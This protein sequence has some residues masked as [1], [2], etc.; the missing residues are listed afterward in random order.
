M[1]TFYCTNCWA[2]VRESATICP[3][4][5]DDIATRQARADYVDKLIAALHHPIPETAVRAACILGE[6]RERKAVPALMQTV[7]ESENLF[8]VDAAVEA[9]GKIGDPQALETLHEAARHASARLRRTVGQALQQLNRET[10]S[11]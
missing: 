2:E 10:I 9:L 5:G 6:R 7:C 11:K 8:L 1:M 3:R 4:C